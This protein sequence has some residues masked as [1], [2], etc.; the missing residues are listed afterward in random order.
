MRADRSTNNMKSSQYFLTK[1]KSEATKWGK[2]KMGDILEVHKDEMFPADL[3]LLGA[4]NNKGENVDMIFI[5][6]MNLDGE[7]NLKPRKIIDSQIV[8]TNDL[9][10]LNAELHYDSPNEN[11]DKWE[12]AFTNKGKKT[13]GDIE[14]IMLRGC[15]LKNIKRAFGVVIYVGK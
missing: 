3:L 8:T 11:L 6:T 5:D 14:N 12:G 15:T 9:N 2:I 7:T 13:H 1:G 4:E 10:E